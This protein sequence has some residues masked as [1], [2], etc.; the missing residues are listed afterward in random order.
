MSLALGIPNLEEIIPLVGVSIVDFGVG[1][2]KPEFLGNSWNIYG[3]YLSIT[4]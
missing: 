1:N 2:L 3:I 4:Y